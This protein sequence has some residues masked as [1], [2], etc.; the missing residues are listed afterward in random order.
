MIEGSHA[1]R[2]PKAQICEQIQISGSGIVYFLK[3]FIKGRLN[4]HEIVHFCKK[5]SALL[6]QISAI[7]LALK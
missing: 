6:R 3:I 4:K 7:A 1:I 2:G 5:F